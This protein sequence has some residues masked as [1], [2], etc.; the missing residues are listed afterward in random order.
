MIIFDFDGTLVNTQHLYNQALSIALLKVNAKYTVE[1]CTN[2]F[3][4]KCWYDAFTQL[5]KTEK[6]NVE[7]VFNEGI[8]IAQQLIFK[9]A[10]PTL[11]TI[12]ALTDLQ[13]HNIPFAI[14]S[15]SN[16][17]EIQTILQQLDLKKYFEDGAIFSRELV[18]KGKPESDIYLLALK[19]LNILPQNAVALEDSISGAK[20]SI[21][22]G[23][24]TCIFAGG[25][26]HVGK[27]K[28]HETFGKDINTF[29]DMKD[30]STFVIQQYAR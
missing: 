7:D 26:G 1:Y 22:A 2:L 28:F 23:I 11:G 27:E 12:D 21:G 8:E 30:F 13:K 5:A 3:D 15:N 17:Y 20:A 19:T 29:Y 6:F 10:Q 24:P 4:G 25:T 16:M 18:K 9:H 14:C